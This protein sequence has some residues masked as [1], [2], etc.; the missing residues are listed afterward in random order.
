MLKISAK[1]QWDHPQWVRQI[2]VKISDF[3]PIS[4]YI[5]ETVQNRDIVTIEG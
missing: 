2:E 1:F 4:H 3:L 5:S